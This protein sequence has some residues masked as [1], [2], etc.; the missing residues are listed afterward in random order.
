[1]QR[2]AQQK[3]ATGMGILRVPKIH[4]RNI[5]TDNGFEYKASNCVGTM[6]YCYERCV[7]LSA[8]YDAWVSVKPETGDVF[9][10][11]EYECGGEVYRYNGTVLANWDESESEFFKELDEYVTDT[12]NFY[13]DDMDDFEEN[14]E[15][16]D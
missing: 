10:Y 12:T 1:M 14:E 2:K 16:C 3:G 8:K 11:I 6:E 9:I 15:D 7:T 5:L 4:N 13:R